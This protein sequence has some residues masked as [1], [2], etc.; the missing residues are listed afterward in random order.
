MLQLHIQSPLLIILHDQLLIAVSEINLLQAWISTFWLVSGFSL[1]LSLWGTSIQFEWMV[2]LL[3]W[4][5][6][7]AFLLC[8]WFICFLVCHELFQIDFLTCCYRNDEKKSTLSILYAFLSPLWLECWNSPAIQLFAF[9]ELL[10]ILKVL[11]QRNV[12]KKCGPSLQRRAFSSIDIFES[13]LKGKFGMKLWCK[14][15]VVFED[16]FG[17]FHKEN[18]FAYAWK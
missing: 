5:C 17:T 2:I 15:E 14:S 1:S 4:M 10:P 12:R 7:S 11:L 18:N 16:C 6:L 8:S 13:L 3:T 9:A